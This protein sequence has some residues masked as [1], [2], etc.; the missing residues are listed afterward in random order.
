[1][2]LSFTKN[3]LHLTCFMFFFDEITEFLGKKRV[4]LMYLDFL[5]YGT[6]QEIINFVENYVQCL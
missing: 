6:T 3:N 4:D 1:M 5:L 2:R